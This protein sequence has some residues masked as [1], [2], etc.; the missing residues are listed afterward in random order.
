MKELFK[1]VCETKQYVLK[2]DYGAL[3]EFK[4]IFYQKEIV[5]WQLDLIWE[6]FWDDRE[7]EEIKIILENKKII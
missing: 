2:L 7:Y 1:S 3:K 4:K 5:K 6:F